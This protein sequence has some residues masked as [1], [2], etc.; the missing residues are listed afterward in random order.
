MHAQYFT[1]GDVGTLHAEGMTEET[2]DT[3]TDPSTFA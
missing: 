1:K 3:E 2:R